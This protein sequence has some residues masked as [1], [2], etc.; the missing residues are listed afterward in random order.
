MS[1]VTLVFVAGQ[2]EGLEQ[3]R[4]QQIGCLC[5]PDS[6]TV[7]PCEFATHAWLRLEYKYNHTGPEFCFWC[8]Q[9]SWQLSLCLAPCSSSSPSSSSWGFESQTL[10]RAICLRHGS[11]LWL[12]LNRNYKSL[13]TKRSFKNTLKWPLSETLPRMTLLQLMKRTTT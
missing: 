11:W 1:I 8:L 6:V 9:N 2:S 3:I 13:G 5:Y 4:G 10:G 7:L 12:G